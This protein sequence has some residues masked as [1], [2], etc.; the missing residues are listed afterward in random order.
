M[1]VCHTGNT[2]W[3]ALTI[4]RSSMKEGVELLAGSA[5]SGIA[6]YGTGTS[7]PTTDAGDFE[8]RKDN[9]TGIFIPASFWKEG[10]NALIS[11]YVKLTVSGDKLYIRS[12]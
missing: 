11:L 8:V 5:N 12:Y 9:P 10:G 1:P 3:T 7:A 6:T 4:D 2:N